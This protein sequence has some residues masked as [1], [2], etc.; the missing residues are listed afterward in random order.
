MLSF[1]IDISH[2]VICFQDSSVSFCDL[3]AHLFS[4]E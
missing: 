3:L 2:L 4:A 1:H